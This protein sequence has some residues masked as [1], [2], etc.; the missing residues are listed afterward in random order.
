MITN[1]DYPDLT[2]RSVSFGIGYVLG[3]PKKEYEALVALYDSTNGNGWFM[4]DNWLSDKDVSEW[5]GV[6]VENNRVKSLWLSDNNLIGSIPPQIGNLDSLK[7]LYLSENGLTGNIPP[8]IGNLGNLV[9]LDLSENG[10]SGSIPPEIGNLHNLTYLYLYE[11]QLSGNIPPEIGNLGYLDELDL[12]ENKLSGSIPPEIGNL[13]RLEYLYLGENKLTGNSA[14]LSGLSLLE[15]LVVENNKLDFGDL[16]TMNVDWENLSYYSYSPQD[17]IITYV[18]SVENNNITLAVHVDGLHNQYQWYLN[19]TPLSG[20]T[21]D[22]YTFNYVTDSTG[23]YNCVVTNPDYPDLT[24]T[25]KMYKFTGTYSVT[26]TVYHDGNPVEGAIITIN[27]QSLQTDANGQAVFNLVNGDY[28]YTVQKTGFRTYTGH[29]TVN[30]ANL[31]ITVTLGYSLL[32]EHQND[33]RVYPNPTH[34]KLTVESQGSLITKLAIMNLSGRKVYESRLKGN[35]ATIDLGGLPQGIY[36]ML[37]ERGK[38]V[39]YSKIIKY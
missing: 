6:Y 11:N 35:R 23:Y 21:S 3:V 20:A 5:N 33:L 1:P 24:L 16:D 25:S 26:F 22:T 4:H 7:I 8:E 15:D 39:V 2:L 13:S 10:L 32:P 36:I 34:D 31:D 27:S 28:I 38:D 29:L 30:N 37:V 14:D 9:E 19:N 12:S 18:E 17:S